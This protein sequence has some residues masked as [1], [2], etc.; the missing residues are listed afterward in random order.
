MSGFSLI[1]LS[2]LTRP[3]T[4]FVEKVSGA[5][6]ALW[7]P[8]QIRRVAQAKADVAITQAQTEIEVTEIQRRAAARFV[9]EETRRQT[10]MENIVAKAIDQIGPNAQAENM[11]DDWIGNFFDKCRNFSDE[12][13]QTIWSRIL[14]GEANAPGSFSRKTVNVLVDLDKD[15][16]EMFVKLCRFGCMIGGSLEPLVFDTRSNIYESNGLTFGVL[17]H[18]ESLGLVQLAPTGF[19]STDLPKTLDVTYHGRQESIALPQSSENT[20]PIGIA[21]YT[22]AGRQLASIVSSNPVPGFYE[23]VYDTWAEQSLVPPRHDTG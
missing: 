21:V 18:L 12:Q 11:D 6:G 1:N 16:A 20:L 14:A 8:R 22:L 5:I 15:S 7:E 19:Q 3:A 23:F 2:G 17:G 4:V 13:M 9:E 10:N